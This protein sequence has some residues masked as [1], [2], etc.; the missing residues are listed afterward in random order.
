VEVVVISLFHGCAV[1][2]TPVLGVL[3]GS[4]DMS[5]LIQSQQ[6]VLN[7]ATRYNANKASDG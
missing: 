1:H 4:P 7:E 2:F 3:V 5:R 6:T